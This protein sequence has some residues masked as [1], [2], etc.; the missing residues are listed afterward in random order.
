MSIKCDSEAEK[1]TTKSA[2]AIQM[3]MI[4]LLTACTTFR[5]TLISV[6]GVSLSINEDVLR[7]Q[8]DT[9]EMSVTSFN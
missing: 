7:A 6:I 1:R 5:H 9:V 8:V 4:I 2:R 3:R